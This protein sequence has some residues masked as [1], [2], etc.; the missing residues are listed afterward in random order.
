MSK[1]DN[2]KK[3]YK[4]YDYFEYIDQL[5]EEER[6]YAEKFYKEF[7]FAD[8][9]RK[10]KEN[11]IKDPDMKKEAIR[12]SNTLQR[13]LMHQKQNDIDPVTLDKIKKKEFMEDASD[14]Y[15]WIEAYHL[16]GYKM[17]S[18]QIMSQTIKNLDNKYIDK[19][20]TLTKYHL[21]MMKLYNHHKET[22]K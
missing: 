16:G 2:K 7:Y 20:T 19:K 21:K 4:V 10:D 1:W 9:Y 14:E 18:D 13:D 15:D 17:A 12:N 22:E 3:N 11:I 6:E 5:S 8:F